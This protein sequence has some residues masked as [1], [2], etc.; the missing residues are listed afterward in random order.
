MSYVPPMFTPKGY[1]L[2]YNNSVLAKAPTMGEIKAWREFYS[3]IRKVETSVFVIEPYKTSI[4]ISDELAAKF[5]ALGINAAIREAKVLTGKGLKYKA[6]EY[7]SKYTPDQFEP[8]GHVD[9]KSKVDNFKGVYFFRSME[10]NR[11]GSVIF[12]QRGGTKNKQKAPYI[13]SFNPNDYDGL[14]T[15]R[16][17]PP[18]RSKLIE[19]LHKQ[20][21]S[22]GE[23]RKALQHRLGISN[24]EAK[25]ITMTLTY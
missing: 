9:H 17:I 25:Q 15:E 23:F 18:T 8:N 11:H 16:T 20:S 3:I 21:N 6:I 19:L 5:H 4:R 12:S 24:R 2:K 7:K 1:Y 13:E 22:I 10:H 14:G